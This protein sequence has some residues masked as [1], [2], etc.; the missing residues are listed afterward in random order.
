MKKR[1]I[2][3]GL[4]ASALIVGTVGGT[5][6]TLAYLTDTSE[7]TQNKFTVGKIDID[8]VDE[9]TPP[10]NE[11]VPNE[12]V[13]K[14]VSVKNTGTNDAVVFIE[15][16]VPVENVTLV[17]NDGTKGTKAYQDI[18]YF[19]QS[20]DGV[21]VQQNNFSSSWEL[22]DDKMDT[23]SKTHTYIF[24]YKT[25]LSESTT[26]ANLFEKF[27][28]K[29]VMENEIS[30]ET[31]QN[32]NVKTYAIQADNIVGANGAIDTSE[33]LTKDVLTEIYNRLMKQ[34]GATEIPLA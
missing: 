4:L 31:V 11:V 2:V 12:Q 21:T 30:S 26:A 27:Q 23:T 17:A 9:Y 3:T 18:V 34:S 6:A 10:E 13:E 32:I 1:K 7:T 25:T 29:N 28:V 19:E 33:T 5:G 24:G 22:L 16:T 14:T 15:L 20:S 8:T